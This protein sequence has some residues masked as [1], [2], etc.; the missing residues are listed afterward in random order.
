MEDDTYAV[1]VQ[2]EDGRYDTLFEVDSEEEGEVEKCKMEAR[3]PGV[4]RVVP[5]D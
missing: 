5:S 4:Y 3:R 1:Q 2:R